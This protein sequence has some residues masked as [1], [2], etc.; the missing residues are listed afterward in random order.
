MSGFSERHRSQ[1][2]E[3]KSHTSDEASAN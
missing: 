1:F 2:R 3:N